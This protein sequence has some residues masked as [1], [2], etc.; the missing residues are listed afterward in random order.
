[1]S[2][3]RNVFIQRRQ[4]I[5]LNILPDNLRPQRY[6]HWYVLGLLAVLAACVLLIPAMTLL[7]STND[8]T[9]EL[10]EQLLGI[11]GQLQG[12]QQDIGKQ[13]ALRDKIS[14]V[15]QSITSTK[16]E[17][18][19][20]SGSSGPLSDGL[21]VISSSTP[22][23]VTL[24]NISRTQH[25]LQASGEAASVESVVAYARALIASNAFSSVTISQTDASVHPLKFSIE[26]VQ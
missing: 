19:S 8:K 3:H 26:A 12:V 1:M 15:E 13:R 10:R 21:S 25:V 11:T 22:T 14:Q 17:R 7:H 5:D 2:V 18:A 24:T 16:Q 20:L 23:D 6:P 4:L 9:S